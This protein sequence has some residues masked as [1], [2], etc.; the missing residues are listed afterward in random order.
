MG[1][2]KLRAIKLCTSTSGLVLP[3]NVAIP[4]IPLT[5]FD[6]SATPAALSYG[7]STASPASHGTVSEII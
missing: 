5:S 2:G 3:F 1:H 4:V 7:C 6:V